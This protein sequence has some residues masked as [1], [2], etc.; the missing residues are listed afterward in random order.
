MTSTRKDR[1]DSEVV[2]NML[3]LSRAGAVFSASVGILAL[4]GWKYDIFWLKGIR[5]NL[6]TMKPSTALALA[7]GGTSLWLLQNNS[8]SRWKSYLGCALAIVVTIIGTLTTFEILS[9]WPLD[10]DRSVFGWLP[11]TS[12]GANR[13]APNTA[14]CFALIGMS[15]LLVDVSILHR[16][17]SQFLAS[18]AGLISLSGLV[19]YAYGIQSMYGLPGFGTMALHTCLTFFVLSGG[20]LMARPR[21]GIMAAFSRNGPK[22]ALLRR[23]SP[24]ALVVPILF[25]WMLL[26]GQRRGIHGTEAGIIILV[27]SQ[28]AFLAF[29]T[30]QVINSLNKIVQEHHRA[31]TQFQDLLKATPDPL[32]ICDQKGEIT[33]V[34]DQVQKVFGFT[35]E[36]LLR[37]PIEMLVQNC[38]PMLHHD[39]RLSFFD[40][41]QVRP[42]GAGAGFVGRRKDGSE[43]PVEVSFNPLN[44]EEGLLISSAIRDVTDRKRFEK[45][46]QTQAAK[47][48]EVTS[49][50]DVVSDAIVLRALDGTI[51]YWNRGAEEI[52]GISSKD[53]IGQVIHTLLSTEFPRPLDELQGEL[54][55]EGLWSGELIHRKCDSTRIILA[56]RWVLKRDEVGAPSAILEINSEIT[57]RKRAEEALRQSEEDYRL[58]VSTVKDYAILMLDPEGCIVSWNDGAER[59]KGYRAEEITGQHFSRF[60]ADE[61]VQKGKPALKLEEAAK[62][63]H[64]EDEGWR[65]RK[66]G[67]R[68]WANVII[69]ALRDE[70]GRL[71]GFVK[72]T[73]DVTDR[74]KFDETLKEKNIELERA[75][76]AKDRFL[77]SV[78]HELRTPLNAIIGFTGTL[79]MKL[80]GPLLPEQQ[81]QLKTIQRSGRHLLS[82]IND[83]LDLA[84]IESGNVEINFEMASCANI[85]ED[86]ETT[87]R[88]IA[89]EKG[90][91]FTVSIQSPNLVVRSDARALR[92]ILLNLTNNAVKFTD[93]GQV[94]LGVKQSTAINSTQTDFYV[95]DTG[96]GIRTEEKERLYRAFTRLGDRAARGI[97]G[98]GLGL[99]VS[100]KLAELLG[101]RITCE[102]DYGRGSTFTLTLLES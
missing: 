41:P 74:R 58:M 50:L 28:I 92:Q 89:E 61:E 22:S 17:L 99:H 6:A 88:P 69:T 2:S 91:E 31:E 66:D 63:G 98:T 64:C 29:F 19:G 23:L 93:R 80:A 77:A 8:R 43:F 45:D 81:R 48:Q 42:S 90:L 79:L 97:E 9:G 60:Y 53:A 68:F 83:I 67:S 86:I 21:V 7:L 84:K 15:L 47:L 38:F 33:L 73:R 24:A 4:L 87:L 3:W 65:V 71:R 75:S 32:V 39:H 62:N 49:L 18:V 25:G 11:G 54:L 35:R 100:Q 40:S 20:I 85:L 1:S 13:M 27:T 26:T 51:E 44:T 70:T 10:V 101:G 78:S 72:V 16:F 5:H 94:R 57:E 46:M 82:L 59:I 34:N 55:C 95:I 52:Y 30:Y 56:S 96:T 12:S 76:L 14:I 37:K 36:E 102:S